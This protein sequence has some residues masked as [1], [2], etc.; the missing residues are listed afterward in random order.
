MKMKD[1]KRLASTNCG[2]GSLIVMG[3][4]LLFLIVGIACASVGD[5]VEDDGESL[6]VIGTALG[7]SFGVFCLIMGAL[8]CVCQDCCCCC[9]R[10][11]PEVQHVPSD[12]GYSQQQCANGEQPIH[13]PIHQQLYP[14]QPYMTPQANQGSVVYPPPYEAHPPFSVTQQQGWPIKANAQFTHPE[15]RATKE[16][17]RENIMQQTR[18]VH[19][20]YINPVFPEPQ[21]MFYP[22]QTTA[23]SAPALDVNPPPYEP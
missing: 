4:G 15:K 13:Q 16:D 11:Y 9:M 21:G 14:R 1:I 20:G 10:P 23:P 7:I 19:Q 22:P 2:K 5:E 18:P 6:L 17:S 3:V 8:I 12:Q